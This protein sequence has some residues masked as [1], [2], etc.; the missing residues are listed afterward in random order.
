MKKHLTWRM[1][2]LPDLEPAGSIPLHRQ[3]YERLCTAIITGQLP[4]ETPLPS[5]RALASELGVARKT[6][7][8]AYEDLSAEGYIVGTVG[9]AT[10]V[11]RLLPDEVF[12]SSKE[13]LGI[14]SAPLSSAAP[15]TISQR[16]S[17]TQARSLSYS[18][19]LPPEREIRAFR[20]GLPALDLFP[21]ELWGRLLARRGRHSLPSLFSYQ[22]A[23]GYRPLREAIAHHLAVA[24]GVRCTP[25][26][27]IVVAGA[28]A[29]MDL[30]FRI[31]LDAGEPV[32]AENPGYFGVHGA[33]VAAGARLV[34]VPVDRQGLDVSAGVKLAPQARL[35]VV[36]PSHQFPLGVTM[37]L[38][39]R[40]ALLNWA[41]QNGAWL[42]EDDYDSEYRYTGHPLEALQ[43]LDRHERVI[44]L[45]SFSKVLFPGLRLGYLVVPSSLIEAFAAVRRL[46]DTHVPVLEQ[47]VVADF[48]LEGHFQRHLRRMRECYAARR[49][50]LIAEVQRTLAG[51]LDLQVS[52]AGLHLAGW[53]P[54][55]SDDQQAAE[56]AAAYGVE[57]VPLSR[58][59][60]V[61]ISRPG[62][63]LGFAAVNEESIRQGVLHLARALEAL[64]KR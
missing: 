64:K 16:G 9:S 21:Y 25:E 6:V 47:M 12:F 33:L 26:Q 17:L 23:A 59:C 20:V 56:Q 27:V 32:W 46:V 28:Q 30:A 14:P 40:L 50:A 35:A 54:Q 43:G 44:Y 62:L 58:L 8:H 4:S 1:A 42:L 45:G 37:S 49:S 13:R 31:L 53:L 11:A 34:P 29:G 18:S 24:R 19:Q 3:L 39:R 61:P 55:G 22:E 41:G 36:A 48:M 7:I 5:T 63:L 57:V 15:A 60:L 52:E 2:S 10:R 51:L 38:T